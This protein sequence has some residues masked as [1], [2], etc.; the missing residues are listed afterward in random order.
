[1]KHPF[2]KQLAPNTRRKFLRLA[3]APVSSLLLA[4][5]GRGEAAAKTSLPRVPPSAPPPPTG[6]LPHW[7]AALPLWQWHEIPNTALSSVEPA[8]RALGVSGPRSKIDAWC[9]ACLKRSGSVYMLG[10]AGGH[11]DYAGNE[12]DALA[13]NVATPRWTQLR[14]PTP[15]ADII[16]ATQFYLDRR[17]S[18]AH[19]YYSTQFIEPLNRMM[20]F[21]SPGAFG[22]FPPAPSGWPYLGDKRSFSFNVATGDWDPPDYVAQFPGSGGQ[23]ANLCVKHPW[24]NDVYYSRN[25]GSGWYRWASATNTWSKLSDVTRAPWYAGAAIDPLRSRMLLVGN[26][27]ALAPEVR[28]LDGSKIAASFSGLGSA[29]LTLTGYPG[30]TYDEAMDRYIVAFNSGNAIRILRVHPETWFVDEP[31]MPGIAPAARTSGLQNA[32]QYVPELRGLVVANRYDGNVY[33]VRTKA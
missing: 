26:D 4:A 33:F 8:I 28:A 15:N 12:V 17:P 29:A 19:T 16:N 1:M 23:F 21:A 18:A 2:F 10:A 13:L 31:A 11:A 32:M 30:V 27:T 20:V 3:A 6:A 5:C 22:P 9:G 24:T 14:G 25:Y 7:V